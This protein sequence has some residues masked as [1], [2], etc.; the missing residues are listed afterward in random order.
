MLSATTLFNPPTDISTTHA[1]LKA[2][3]LIEAL[4]Y[5]ERFQG[6]TV[7]IKYGGSSLNHPEIQ[8]SLLADILWMKK[9]GIHPVV[10]HGG[11]PDIN[12]ML[13]KLD[14]PSTFINGLRQTSAET[15]DVVEMV[16]SGSINKDLVQKLQ[17]SGAKAIGLSGKDGGMLQAVP[18]QI[19]GEAPNALGYVGEISEV[20][21]ELIH[22]MIEQGYIPVIAPLASGTGND[23][24]T[25]YNV[26]ADEAAVAIAGALKAQKLVFLTDTP[27]VLKDPN[28]TQS[29]MSKLTPGEIEQ[30]IAS[31][32]ISGGMIPKVTACTD[33]LNHG[34]QQVHILDG[35]LAHA[36]LLEVFTDDG[37]GTLVVP[38]EG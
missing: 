22:L 25:T 29:L 19:P 2:E 12:Q 20:N 30:Y 28:D 24:G 4:P 16:L 6:I 7:V 8:A 18:K 11:G 26:N 33:A 37:I 3:V 36:L 21:P 17:Q 34:V 10:V 14:I 9:V 1:Q 38:D 27:G 5:I 35:R 23:M 31:G 13:S 32:V 15:V